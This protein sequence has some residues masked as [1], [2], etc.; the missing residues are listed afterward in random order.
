MKDLIPIDQ[1]L[2]SP[3][4]VYGHFWQETKKPGIFRCINCKQVGYCPGCLLT[5]PPHVLVMRCKL[6]EEP[7]HE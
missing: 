1:A 4:E 7:S 6:H 5:L 3:C 2:R